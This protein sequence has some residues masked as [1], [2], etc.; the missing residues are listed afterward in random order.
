MRLTTENNL[1]HRQLRSY[2]F[3]RHLRDD[4]PECM[5]HTT[6]TVRLQVSSI[7][8]LSPHKRA[9]SPRMRGLSHS[10]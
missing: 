5:R 3:N 4:W 6:L 8:W 10:S 2:S 9:P 7:E 1:R